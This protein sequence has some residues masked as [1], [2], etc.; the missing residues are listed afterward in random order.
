[1]YENKTASEVLKEALFE[2]KKDYEIYHD[3]F[4]SCVDEVIDFAKK[5]N[6]DI[7]QGDFDTVVTFGRGR[8]STG[9]THRFTLQLEKNGKPQRKTLQFQVYGMEKKYELNMYIS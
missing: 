4:T 7:D 8:P 9:K 1:M 5:N 3:S 2:G 6:Y